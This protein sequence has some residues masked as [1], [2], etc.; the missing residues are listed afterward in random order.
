MTVTRADIAAVQRVIN[1]EVSLHEMSAGYTTRRF[2]ITAATLLHA[3][4]VTEFSHAHSYGLLGDVLLAFDKS[5]KRKNVH[6]KALRYK[7]LAD[8]AQELKFTRLIVLRRDRYNAGLSLFLPSPLLRLLALEDNAE[9]ALWLAVPVIGMHELHI[10]AV[11]LK[12]AYEARW[13]QAVKRVEEAHCLEGLP[14]TPHAVQVLI[15]DLQYAIATA[16][17]RPVD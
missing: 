8:M 16:S 6:Q 14:A 12:E 15:D 13:Q 11:R 4:G 9:K 7:V 10:N 3:A 17:P 5:G 1:G 2:V